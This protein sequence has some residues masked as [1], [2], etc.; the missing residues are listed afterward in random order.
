MTTL[1]RY[2]A[3]NVCKAGG[4]VLLILSALFG[5]LSLGEEL[6]QVGQGQFTSADA[7][8]IVVLTAPSRAVELLPV[9]AL[10]GAVLGLGAM[11]NHHEIIALRIAGVSSR[12]LVRALGQVALALIV[13]AVLV[14]QLLIP[15]AE[16][17]AAEVRSKTL[18][19]TALGTSAEFWSRHENR[20]IRV[21]GVDFG[22][23]PRD[24]EIYELGERGR[25]S[26]LIQAQRADIIDDNHW[27]LHDVRESVLTP[28]AVEESVVP[29]R[30]WPSFLSPQQIATFVAPARAL[31]AGDLYRY[32]REM[33]GTGIN[34]HRYE[35]IFWRQMTLPAALF[36]MI[37]FGLP[38][39]L[40]AVRERSAG[41]RTMIG[42]GVGIAFYLIDQITG[43]LTLIF[44]IPAAPAAFAPALL[45]LLVAV[46]AIHKIA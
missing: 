18:Q 13:V 38:F 43:H 35:S 45:L 14:Q 15:G 28:T 17:R 23:I 21:G 16:R 2:L 39:V 5:F 31:S 37:L 4:V 26:R 11:A 40:G 19:Q 46:T 34:T 27:I 9:T 1:D 12:G 36:A 25:L 30:E 42:G 24:I 41:F 7:F 29:S 33:Q 44:E 22:H 10:L 3:V 32:I 8:W 6:E 20:F